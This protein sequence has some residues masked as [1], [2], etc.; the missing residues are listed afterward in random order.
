MK[1]LLVMVAAVI[2]I[3][4]APA[5][6]VPISGTF[7]IGPNAG[8]LLYLGLAGHLIGQGVD[9]SAS[10]DTN[11]VR[12]PVQPGQPVLASGLF[13]ADTASGIATIGQA[14]PFNL[15]SILIATCGTFSGQ[16]TSAL[17]TAPPIGLPMTAAFSV[18]FSLSMSVTSPSPSIP[19]A[20]LEGEG[21]AI[22][23]LRQVSCGALGGA[24]W[25]VRDIQATLTAIP[26]PSTLLLVS[27]ALAGMYARWRRGQRSGPLD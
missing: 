18:P 12:M 1:R 15:C 14:P 11:L 23:T 24:C 10:G 22:V 27:S 13:P 21:S 19:S 2:V 8:P 6:A 17:V 7:Q 20:N 26:E 3:S 25:E 5:A 4:Q 9:V 16:Y